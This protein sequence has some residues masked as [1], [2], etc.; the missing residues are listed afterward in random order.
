[1]YQQNIISALSEIP[2]LAGDFAED[3]GFDRTGVCVLRHPDYMGGGPGGLTFTLT[4]GSNRLTWTCGS[5]GNQAYVRQPI[6]AN[7]SFPAGYNVEP[8]KVFFIG[9]LEPEPYM[10]IVIQ[11]GFNFYRHLYMGFM[12]KF[13]DYEGGEVISGHN[14]PHV[15]Q[16]SPTLDWLSTSLLHPLFGSNQTSLNTRTDCGGVHIDHADN[17]NPWRNFRSAGTVTSSFNPDMFDGAEAVGGFNDGY[18]DMMVAYG[19]SNLAGASVMAPINLFASQP[20][21]E[22]V[23]FRPIGRPAGVRLINI[24][25]LSPESTNTIAD[26]TWYSFAALSKRDETLMPNYLGVSSTKYRLFETSRN[27]GYAYRGE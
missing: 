3:L 24:A 12:E 9:M 6:L 7:E 1:M 11:F 20:V 14:G 10:A 5:P 18:N 19:L 25:N 26:E 16:L 13:G 17:P 21:S 23:R 4:E 8:T 22:E 2:A 27:L 15:T